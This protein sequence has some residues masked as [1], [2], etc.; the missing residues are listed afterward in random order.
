[1]LLLKA[2]AF[3]ERDNGDAARK[4]RTAANIQT[5]ET[6][7][8]K[9][10][11]A[12]RALSDYADSLASIVEAGNT[13]RSSAKQLSGALGSPLFAADLD[14][15]AKDAISDLTAAQLGESVLAISERSAELND[16]TKHLDQITSGANRAASWINLESP[17]EIAKSLTEVASQFVALKK[18]LKVDGVDEDLLKKVDSTKNAIAK[19][20]ETIENTLT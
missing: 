1:M 19:L 15:V 8:G 12:M 20:R 3:H 9:R 5:L 6:E 18:K 13:G 17:V 11:K 10:V 7:W 16:L 4:A 2:R 14:R